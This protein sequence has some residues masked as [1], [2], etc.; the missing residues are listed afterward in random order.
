[1][2]FAGWSTI[3]LT[4]PIVLHVRCTIGLMFNHIAELW[5]REGRRW[6]HT[7]TKDTLNAISF[8]VKERN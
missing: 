5:G 7:E 6:A 4:G 8:A 1:M 3:G 2:Q